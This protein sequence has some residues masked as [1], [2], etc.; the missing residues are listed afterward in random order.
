MAERLRVSTDE[1]VIIV[2]AWLD[3]AIAN[4][5]VEAKLSEQE[6][7]YFHGCSPPDIS[8]EDYLHRLLFYTKHSN[9]VLV[10]ALV[11]LQRLSNTQP[12]IEFIPETIHRLILSSFVA[13]A[14][15]HEDY[16]LSSAHYAAIGGVS[17]SEMKRL[18]L[19][20]LH[21]LDF[22]LFVSVESYNDTIALVTKTIQV[23]P[24]RDMQ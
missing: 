9:E 24:E 11:Y 6:L 19:C 8:I 17:L 7:T 13:S 23:S 3:F 2:T 21:R 20:M 16:A 18:E 4:N 10:G 22:C 1:F 14:K 15:M 12:F 5:G